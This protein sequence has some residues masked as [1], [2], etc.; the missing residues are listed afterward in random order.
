MDNTEYLYDYFINHIDDSYKG[1]SYLTDLQSLSDY[2]QI[3]K[4]KLNIESDGDKN[5]PYYNRY[6]QTMKIRNYLETHIEEYYAINEWELFIRL[7]NGDKFIFDQY[8]NAV[9]F[10]N[11][12]D[13]ELT[14]EQEQKEFSRN[15]KKLMDHKWINQEEL[16]EKLGITQAT[17]SNYCNSRRIPDSITLIKIARILNCSL[18]ELFYRKF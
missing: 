14:K 4:S 17:V 3:I 11:D 9:H 1:R 5:D 16:A 18:D 7:T 8:Y 15:L 10:V 12:Y 2:K 6:I 13:K